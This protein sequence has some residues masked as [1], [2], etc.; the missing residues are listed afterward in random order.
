MSHD[1]YR[2][3]H[4]GKFLATVYIVVH[5]SCITCVLFV[6]CVLFAC[7]QLMR[8]KH[9]SIECVIETHVRCIIEWVK[10]MVLQVS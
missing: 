3:T 10:I 5:V 9:K 6:I 1:C 4:C 2:V 8:Y 7:A